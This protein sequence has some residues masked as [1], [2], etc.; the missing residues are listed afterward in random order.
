MGSI[1]PLIFNWLEESLKFPPSSLRSETSF[2]FCLP[3]LSTTPALYFF[4]MKRFLPSPEFT[5]VFD[6]KIF[7][8]FSSF[9][10]RAILFSLFLLGTEVSGLLSI[11]TDSEDSSFLDGFLLVRLISERL[12]EPSWCEDRFIEFKMVT[13]SLELGLVAGCLSRSFVMKS[14]SSVE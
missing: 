14:A 4:C 2:E 9:W 10:S 5:F 11:L 1:S 6:L 8:L 3:W 13:T 12:V 7:I